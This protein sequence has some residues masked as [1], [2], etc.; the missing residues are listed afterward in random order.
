MDANASWS[1]LFFFLLFL[2]AGIY[3]CIRVLRLIL[4]STFSD[5][6]APGPRIPAPAPVRYHLIPAINPCDHPFTDIPATELYAHLH[7]GHF[8]VWNYLLG[9]ARPRP[10]RREPSPG[11]WRMAHAEDHGVVIGGM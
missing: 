5:L 1:E 2:A 7:D 9:D 6:V 10:G 3:G 4:S 11:D 8:E